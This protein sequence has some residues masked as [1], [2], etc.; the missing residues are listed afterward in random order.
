MGCVL[1]F[2]S[3]NN[4]YSAV[5]VNEEEIK[6]LSSIFDETIKVDY[7]FDFKCDITPNI[8][9]FLKKLFEYFYSNSI[10]IKKNLKM[11]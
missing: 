10:E 4:E 11:Y 3:S 9:N 7:N 8:F 6:Q 1:K 5:I 2:A